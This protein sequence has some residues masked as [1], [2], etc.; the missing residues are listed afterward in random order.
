MPSTGLSYQRLCAGSYEA[1]ATTICKYPAPEDLLPVTLGIF[2]GKIEGNWFLSISFTNWTNQRCTLTMPLNKAC[3]NMIMENVVYISPFELERREGIRLYV[4]DMAPVAG[5]SPQ[6]R[7]NTRAPKLLETPP[8]AVSKEAVNLLDV[9]RDLIILRDC[10]NTSEEQLD[11]FKGLANK[12]VFIVQGLL[13]PSCGL[14]PHQQFIR[15]YKSEKEETTKSKVPRNGI[16][17]V[18]PP[19]QIQ[20]IP[21]LK[22]AKKRPGTSQTPGSPRQG[23]KR[24][25]DFNQ[26][27]EY[28]TVS[29]ARRPPPRKRHSLGSVGIMEP[30]F[31]DDSRLVRAS[32]KKNDQDYRTQVY[33]PDWDMEGDRSNLS[34]Y[35]H[36]AESQG[37]RRTVS[38]GLPARR[39]RVRRGR[40]GGR[41]DAS[42]RRIVSGPVNSTLYRSETKRDHG[43][44][45]GDF[46][47]YRSG[48]KSGETSEDQGD[49]SLEMASESIYRRPMGEGELPGI[50]GLQLKS[51]MGRQPRAIHHSSP[52]PFTDI[53]EEELRMRSSP[54]HRGPTSRFSSIRDRERGERRGSRGH[55]PEFSRNV[56]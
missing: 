21:P 1:H 54:P 28:A 6:I 2:Q 40:R 23:D 35:P 25:T 36:H 17:T 52:G 41:E 12:G 32:E 8:L 9:T 48:E 16:L 18:S 4:T 44:G 50:G 56:D 11:F 14:G 38:L 42:E 24:G 29:P 49:D 39:P 51:E 53:V 10:M 3:F 30:R 47:G 31:R 37:G 15:G 45:S 7:V 19:Q 22:I 46:G 27:S 33:D 13:D 20:E 34:D 26:D 43:R 5:L 55:G